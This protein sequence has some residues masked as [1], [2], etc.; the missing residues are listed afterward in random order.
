M[1]FDE[2]RLNPAIER[3]AQGGPGF[4]TSV[5]ELWSGHE[6]R[7][8]NWQRE[9]GRW[10]IGY[11]VR[12]VATLKDV[13]AF[14]RARQGRARGW[15]FKDWLDYTAIGENLG[16]ATAMQTTVQLRKQYV[17]GAVT[18]NRFIYKPVVGTT[19]IYVDDI[20]E[21]DV[22][23]N[24]TTGVVTF[25]TPLTGGEIITADFEFDV[26]VR[27]DIDQIQVSLDMFDEAQEDGFGAIPNIPI[28]ELRQ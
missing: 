10:D 26:P 21:D 13:L 7:N 8:V 11:G 16:V 20:E 27:F 24:T 14:F 9:R 17:S 2:V 28:V 23:I 19:V 4:R 15:R 22:T 18:Y 25:L 1:S 3:G 6:K 12:D 5:I